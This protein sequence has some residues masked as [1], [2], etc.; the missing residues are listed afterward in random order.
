MNRAWWIIL[1]GVAL[2]GSA[3]TDERRYVGEDGLYQV[4]LDSDTMAAVEAEDAQVFIVERRVEL[5]VKPPSETALEDLYQAAG[6]FE[7]LPFPRLPW[8]ESGDIAVQVDFTLTNLGD[9][10]REVAVI[11]NGFNEFHEYNPGVTVIDDEPVADYAQ[12]E[13]LYELAPLSRITRSIREEEFDEMAVDL[14][15]VVNGAPNSNLV[16]FFENKSPSDER[17]Q[18]FIPEI[19][20]GL[21]GFRIGLRATAAARVLLEASVRV[22]DV[23]SFLAEE[24]EEPFM[25]QPELFAPVAAEEE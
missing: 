10:E 17:S 16:V 15:T 20:P 25:V 8:I 22:R 5:P 24:D 11:V 7:N 18:P 2:S 19:V 4:A 21:M 6:E 14:A 23:E 3:C 13:R 1:G 9:A 12:W